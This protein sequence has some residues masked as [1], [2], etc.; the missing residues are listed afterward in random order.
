MPKLYPV[1]V[2]DTLEIPRA[3]VNM[4]A[5]ML[6]VESKSLYAGITHGMLMIILVYRTLTVNMHQA[7]ALFVVKYYADKLVALATCLEVHGK[8]PMMM[9]NVADAQYVYMPPLP[10]EELTED[11]E[12]DVIDLAQMAPVA[13][14][15]M[16]AIQMS[17]VLP[18]LYGRAVRILA[19]NQDEQTQAEAEPATQPAAPAVRPRTPQ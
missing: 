13:E 11:H 14:F 10:S 3:E 9:L 12:M 2:L 5:S 17:L 15:P 8:R 19:G 18:E 6:G 7:Q 16:P 1:D 4:L